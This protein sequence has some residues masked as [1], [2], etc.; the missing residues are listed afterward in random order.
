MTAAL[1]QLPTAARRDVENAT[2]T[3]LAAGEERESVRVC[4]LLDE[5]ARLLQARG[6][7]TPRT[8]PGAVVEALYDV[9]YNE[10]TA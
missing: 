4:D 7:L 6:L 5:C 9:L 8:R 1:R 2:A 3:V 10:V